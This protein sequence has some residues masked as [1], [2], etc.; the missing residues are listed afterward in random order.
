MRNSKT[1]VLL[2]LTILLASYATRYY[3][4]NAENSNATIELG[5][6]ILTRNGLRNKDRNGK[7]FKRQAK[8][9][10]R[11]QGQKVNRELKSIISN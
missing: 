7:F 3:K 8:H 11:K 2:L 6:D 5:E 1:S 4:T 10:G 9:K